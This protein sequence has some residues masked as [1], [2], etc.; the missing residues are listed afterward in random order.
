MFMFEHHDAL[1]LESLVMFLAF[2]MCNQ[3]L[4]V[5]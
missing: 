3:Y 5:S 4:F 1:L 2:M